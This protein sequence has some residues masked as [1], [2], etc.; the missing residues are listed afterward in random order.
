MKNLNALVKHGKE[1]REKINSQ[2]VRQEEDGWLVVNGLDLGLRGVVSVRHMVEQGIARAL[3]SKDVEAIAYAVKRAK[4]K[5]AQGLLLDR[6]EAAMLTQPNTWFNE[7][8]TEMLDVNFRNQTQ[9]ASH[10]FLIG[11][12]DVT[13]AVGWTS[14]TSGTKIRT[15]F[16]E[17][18]DYTFGGSSTVRA[19]WVPDA[20][21]TQ[22][23]K[24]DTTGA[25]IV[26]TGSGTIRGACLM[27]AQA[28]DGSNDNTGYAW[29]GSRLAADRTAASTDE[30]TFK[31]EL[32]GSAS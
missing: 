4:E 25:T 32:S 27:T 28:K 26:C 12:L 23:I 19:T 11:N 9:Y 17:F 18:T 15:T 29:A 10:Y 6:V 5:L 13:P 21:A 31:H 24:N 7:G 14:G 8:I 20:A 3:E 30:F 16:G 22:A 2:G 1:I